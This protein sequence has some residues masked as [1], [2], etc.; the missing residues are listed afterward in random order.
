MAANAPAIAETPLLRVNGA[1]LASIIDKILT[2]G[3][4]S[5]PNEEQTPLISMPLNQDYSPSGGDC[6]YGQSTMIDEAAA[7]AT[8]WYFRRSKPPAAHPPKAHPDHKTT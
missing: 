6:A 2:A 8:P 4:A 5:P 1:D 7:P 3:A